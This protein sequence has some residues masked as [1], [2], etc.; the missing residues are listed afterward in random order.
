MFRRGSAARRASRSARSWRGAPRRAP[1]L[2]APVARF[3]WLSPAFTGR[4]S[5]NVIPIPTKSSTKLSPGHPAP[6]LRLVLSH[7]VVMLNQPPK[8]RRPPRRPR[9]AFQDL[10]RRFLR[11]DA[12]GSTRLAPSFSSSPVIGGPRG[13]CHLSIRCIT[14][15]RA[16]RKRENSRIGFDIRDPRVRASRATCITSIDAHARALG[17]VMATTGDIKETQGDSR[18]TAGASRETLR[19]LKNQLHGPMHLWCRSARAA[20]G[21]RPDG[22]DPRIGALSQEI[23]PSES[24]AADMGVR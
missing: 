22:R 14:A 4:P 16:N 7:R 8:Q 13:G 24:N 23:E 21:K 17:H 15:S 1:L 12:T 18:G 10:L 9:D 20:G 11:T 5:A 3:F 19:R 2:C 6:S